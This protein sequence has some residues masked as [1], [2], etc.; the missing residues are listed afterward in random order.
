[1]GIQAH[2]ELNI[3][4][5]VLN[6]LY[7]KVQG[8]TSQFLNTDVKEFGS[9]LKENF[10]SMDKNADNY[11]TKDEISASVKRDLRNKESDRLKTVHDELTKLGAKIEEKEDGLIINGKTPLQGSATLNTYCDHRLAMTWF[12]AGLISE[13]PINI[14]GFKWHKTSFPEFLDKFNSLLK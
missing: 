6:S 9:Y 14:N 12:I 8:Y 4:D 10:D 13:T 7:T 5:K 1:M 11:L 2:N 3:K